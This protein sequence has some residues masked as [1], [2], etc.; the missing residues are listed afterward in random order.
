MCISDRSMA[1]AVVRHALAAEVDGEP[2]T[3]QEGAGL[4]RTTAKVS[5]FVVARPGRRALADK[6][7]EP[8]REAVG[9]VQPA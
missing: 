6:A 4:R 3:V 5:F 2:E 1:A 7:E 9:Q 8:A